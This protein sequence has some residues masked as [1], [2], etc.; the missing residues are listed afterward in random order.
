MKLYLVPRS[1]L[2]IAAMGGSDDGGLIIDGST[3]EVRATAGLEG[4]LV[5]ELTTLSGLTPDNPLIRFAKLSLGDWEGAPSA[6][7]S[8]GSGDNQTENG[9]DEL[10]HGVAKCELEEKNQSSVKSTHQIG[11]KNT[12]R[13]D[14]V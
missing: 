6:N 5:R 9:G 12:Q 11:K 1:N 8:L 2:S 4:D 3:T 7:L 10:T 14:I 13:E